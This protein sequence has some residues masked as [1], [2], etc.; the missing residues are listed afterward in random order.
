[1]F[2]KLGLLRFWRSNRHI[3]C[4]T[5]PSTWCIFLYPN[6]KTSKNRHWKWN[7]VIERNR[8]RTNN[9]LFR[10]SGMG[11]K[12]LNFR[13]RSSGSQRP[14][15]SHLWLFFVG[16]GQKFNQ[17]LALG[18]SQNLRHSPDSYSFHH[19]ISFLQGNFFRNLCVGIK[20]LG[21]G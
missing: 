9:Q 17:L 19:L 14:I 18:Q 10:A 5:F 20:A 15:P 8:G 11:K 2:P 3:V 6:P 13:Q 1:M 16:F 12:I 4:R 7:S 21:S